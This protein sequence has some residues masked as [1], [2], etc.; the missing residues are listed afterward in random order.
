VLA[1]YALYTFKPEELT[2]N[3]QV[4]Q[5]GEITVLEDGIKVKVD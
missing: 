1:D 4:F 5:P 3:G 2:F